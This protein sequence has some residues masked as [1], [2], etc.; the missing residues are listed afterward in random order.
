VIDP[1]DSPDVQAALRAL[2]DTTAT[3][4]RPKPKPGPGPFATPLERADHHLERIAVALESIAQSLSYY[5][6]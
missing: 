3:P 4:P 5:R 1:Y 6:P 2:E